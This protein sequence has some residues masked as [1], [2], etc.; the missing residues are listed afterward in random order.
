MAKKA[1]VKVVESQAFH[2]V[3]EN[4]ELRAILQGN[5]EGMVAMLQMFDQR[6]LPRLTLQV[7]N[8]GETSVSLAGKSGKQQIGLVVKEDGSAGVA[9]HHASGTYALS[10][11]TDF[12]E[13]A[14]IDLYDRSGQI[15]VWRRNST[16]MGEPGA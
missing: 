5:V 7:D 12:N 10:F 14:S 3:N 16:Q 4:G 2:L 11:G 1:P 8:K 15:T 9:I 6:G 13:D